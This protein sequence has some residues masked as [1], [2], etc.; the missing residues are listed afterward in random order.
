MDAGLPSNNHMK[1]TKWARFFR[2]MPIKNNDHVCWS[3]GFPSNTHRQA[4]QGRGFSGKRPSSSKQDGLYVP[5]RR[6][7]EKV[8]LIRGQQSCIS[9]AIGENMYI[10]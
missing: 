3:A 5:K 1:S 10:N 9:V 7:T 8:L 6:N 4:R 2:T